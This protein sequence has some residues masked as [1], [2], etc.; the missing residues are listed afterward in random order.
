MSKKKD[1]YSVVYFSADGVIGSIC[2]EGYPSEKEYIEIIKKIRSK[3]NS[4]API[5]ILNIFKWGKK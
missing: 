1:L 5:V 4:L 2:W 3:I